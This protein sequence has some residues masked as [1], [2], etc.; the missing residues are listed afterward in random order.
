MN[1]K[2]RCAHFGPAKPFLRQCEDSN[3]SKTQKRKSKPQKRKSEVTEEEV[4]VG[5]VSSWR[6]RRQREPRVDSE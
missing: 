6:E 2:E 3:K 1:S 5:V 4:K